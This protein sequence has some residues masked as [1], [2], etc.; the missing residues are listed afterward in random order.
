M[1]DKSEDILTIL[2][3]NKSISN[4]T[5]DSLIRNGFDSNET[6]NALDLDLDLP[7]M[8][9]ISFQQKMCLRKVFKE[10]DF[11]FDCYSVL[12]KLKENDFENNQRLSEESN[13]GINNK[14]DENLQ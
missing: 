6:L 8:T 3:Q 13:E 10:N 1:S 14:I 4:Q 7:Q 11:G 5:I 2:R 12:F 9:D